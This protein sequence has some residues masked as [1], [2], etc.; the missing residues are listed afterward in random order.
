MFHYCGI[1]NSI[2]KILDKVWSTVPDRHAFKLQ[3]NFDGL[4][5][6][7]STSTQF[8][9]ILGMLQGYTKKPLLIGL[10]CGT[11]KPSSLAEYLHDLVQKL[12]TLKSGFLYKQK[13]FF[14]NVLSVVCDSPAR[15]FIRGVKSHNAYHGCD[16]CHQKGV[17]KSNRM[18]FPEVNARRRTNDTFRQAEDEE[19]HVHHSPLADVGID[20]VACFPYDYMHLVCLGVMKRLLDLWISTTGPLRCRI[21]SSLASMVSDKLL[22][23]RS[24]LEGHGH[25]LNDVGGKPQN[26]DSSCYT[27]VWLC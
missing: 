10:F 26:S 23:L 24:L 6:F 9:P 11:S 22:S 20:M 14:V 2:E 15:A 8:W 3:L 16:K 7:K 13:T 27:L 1:L 12:K 25:W 4:P 17:R 18:T 21:S 5:L 19:H